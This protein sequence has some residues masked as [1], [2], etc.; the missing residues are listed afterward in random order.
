MFHRA[1]QPDPLD[2]LGAMFVI[3]GLGGMKAGQWAESLRTQLRID[4]TSK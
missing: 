3:E 2:L 1:S 4:A